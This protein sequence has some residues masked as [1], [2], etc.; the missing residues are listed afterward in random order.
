MAPDLIYLSAKYSQELS[1]AGLDTVLYSD[2]NYDWSERSSR[3]FQFVKTI[4]LYLLPFILMLCAHYKIMLTLQAASQS[5]HNK[6]ESMRGAEMAEVRLNTPTQSPEPD[7][8]L[9]NEQTQA[10]KQKLRNASDH[11][12]HLISNQL[13]PADQQQH[14]SM[15]SSAPTESQLVKSNSAHGEAA[16]SFQKQIRFHQSSNEE[17]DATTTTLKSP[18]E[19]SLLDTQRVETQQRS[20]SSNSNNKTRNFRFKTFREVAG[21]FSRKFNQ[22]S[23]CSSR[24][25]ATVASSITTAQ[26]N[27]SRGSK[28]SVSSYQI[29]LSPD[30]TDTTGRTT[31]SSSKQAPTNS[32]LAQN[33]PGTGPNQTN[34]LLVTM[35]N[36]TKLDS[37]KAAA[38][39]LM[40]IVV[41]FGI[42][43][44]PVHLI[45][46]LR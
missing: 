41:M 44:L 12:L 36:K 32:K 18:V 1:E 17:D 30:E 21:K 6:L 40:T 24:S 29:N 35:H 28:G 22:A 19:V 8:S 37:R 23:I 14:C 4:L 10:G 7:S 9:T 3:T 2:C 11:E 33:K 38:K 45:N 39:M 34:Q 16:T 15:A 13:T 43:Y 42:C 46:F 25:S 26:L 27:E 5:A 20:R 31:V